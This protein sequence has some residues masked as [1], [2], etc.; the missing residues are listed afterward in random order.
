MHEIVST[1]LQSINCRQPCVLAPCQCD[2]STAQLPHTCLAQNFGM[3]FVDSSHSRA[4][5]SHS[6]VIARPQNAYIYS[7][8][9]HNQKHWI[10][11]IGR[12]TKSEQRNELCVAQINAQRHTANA[13]M[14]LFIPPLLPHTTPPRTLIDAILMHFSFLTIHIYMHN[15]KPKHAQTHRGWTMVIQC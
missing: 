11:T 14:V 10:S 2:Q 7:G 1:Y 5:A 12:R 15:H 8:T 6:S 9:E 13:Q 3:L 4:R